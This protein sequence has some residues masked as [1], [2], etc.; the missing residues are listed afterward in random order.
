M[1]L[2]DLIND[3]KKQY[4]PRVCAASRLPERLRVLQSAL[5]IRSYRARH[6]ADRQKR[7]RRSS[8]LDPIG[9]KAAIGVLW[10]QLHRHTGGKAA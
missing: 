6:G 5:N 9:D 4:Y 2:K 1:R 10:R 3:S 8:R 7:D